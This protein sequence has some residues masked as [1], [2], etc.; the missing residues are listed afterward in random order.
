VKYSVEVTVTAVC[1]Y[2]VEVEASSEAS[3]ED[4]AHSQWR[5]L[6]PSDFQVDKGYVESWDADTTQL[7]W[8][9]EEC[10]SIISEVVWRRCD[11]LCANCYAADQV[12]QR[13]GDY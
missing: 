3:A 4:D 11:E 13:Q 12:R 8:E 5:E 9:C 7:T 10:G 2:T 6:M 1:T